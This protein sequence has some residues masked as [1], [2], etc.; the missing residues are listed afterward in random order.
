MFSETQRLEGGT[1]PQP[2]TQEILDVATASEEMLEDILY[3][4]DTRLEFEINRIR[5]EG[6]SSLLQWAYVATVG[7]GKTYALTRAASKAAQKGW[8]VAIRAPTTNHAL[9][10]KAEIDKIC[11][12]AA[13]I[14]LGREQRNPNE[15]G[16]KMCPR[17]AEVA[18]AQSV[19]G[20][21]NDVCGS[22]RRGYCKHHPER[23]LEGCGY[24][25]QDLRH[26]QIIIFAGDSILEFVPRKPMQQEGRSHGFEFD[27]IM[28]DEFDP[29]G[30]IHSGNGDI[31]FDCM[32]AL[33]LKLSDD[34][35]IQEILAMFIQEIQRQVLSGNKYLLPLFYDGPSDDMTFDELLEPSAA[36]SKTSEQASAPAQAK[37][38]AKKRSPADK[39]TT[40]ETLGGI[41]EVAKA[42]VPKTIGKAQF[43]KMS[44]TQIYE[45]NKDQCKVRRVVLSLAKIC[46]LM[47]QA[48][49]RDVNELK[50]LEIRPEH[51]GISIN[52]LKR[53]NLQYYFP[54]VLVFD[55]TL[56]YDLVKCILPNLEIRTQRQVSDGPG[57]KRFQLIDTSLSYSTLKSSNKW[58]ARLRLWAELCH[59][60]FGLTGLLLPKFLR[61]EIEHQLNNDIMLGH[62]GN[63]K[64]TNKFKH[65]GA[66][67]VASRP[68][69]NPTQAERAAAVISWQN[70]Q[71]LD[72]AQV[73]YPR[74]EVPIRYR[75]DT[76]YSWYVN[77]DKHPDRFVEAVRQSITEAS[78]EQAAGRGRSTRRS[79]EE[80]LTEYL[81]TSV[82]TN[83]PVDGIFSVAQFKAATSWI[84]VFLQAGLWI[85]LGTKGAGALLHKLLLAVKS[86]RPETLYS[87]LI[88]VS[89]FENADSASRWR[90]KQVQDNF[91]ISQLAN[92]IDDAIK[93][94]SDS[95]EL[96]CSP[97]P[98]ATFQPITAKVRGA[99]YFAQAYIRVAP[100]QTA[101]E[102]LLAILGPFAE[103]VEIEA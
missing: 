16:T 1:G 32:S 87:N 92:A 83:R 50:H 20:D 66:L 96:L 68:A 90:K 97:F 41:L 54:P 8:R 59:I 40:F 89:A 15:P 31:D 33:N 88:G 3:D 23:H 39:I 26:Y 98:L 45:I 7:T 67:I 6:I 38:E 47:I 4:I 53:I 57:V 48:V 58:S 85:A 19:G 36:R 49:D 46:E 74:E 62:F 103:D 29:Q 43:R 64:G 35:Q 52:Y 100:G 84:G 65:V 17:A 37:S 91:E 78:V 94:K 21:P 70:I 99:R 102:A 63:L 11:A 75:Q 24:K 73:W 95:V 34:S 44:A 27:L 25:G 72:G 71:K 76:A 69:I 10:I 82:P 79:E 51:G 9:E 14:W 101:K 80:L 13:G 12:G 56:Q 22:K 2:S 18:A 42:A 81:L 28:L 5:E 77:Q 55:A 30:L 86:Q 60:M 93:A 61:D